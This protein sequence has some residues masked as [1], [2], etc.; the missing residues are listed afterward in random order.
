VPEGRLEVEGVVLSVK[1]REGYM[2]GVVLKMVVDG[3]GFRVW[4][5]VPADIEDDIERGSRVRFTATLTRADDDP[6]FGFFKRPAKAVLVQADPEPA[7]AAAGGRRGSVELPVVD[8]RAGALVNP[9]VRYLADELAALRAV[10]AEDV[11]WFDAERLE[12]RLH[13]LL[14]DVAREIRSN[15]PTLGAA[16]RRCAKP[17]SVFLPVEMR[18]RHH[19]SR[20][21]RL[22]A[23]EADQ[24]ALR[25][26]RV[27]LSEGLAALDAWRSW[28]REQLAR[29]LEA[30]R[31]YQQAVAHARGR[32]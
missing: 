12:R 5:T 1:E 30:H 3:G 9:Y 10:S 2:G 21:A 15:G 13:D 17:L 24:A 19:A 14:R 4:G 8:A 7:D 26:M 29:R 25:A 20:S 18:S 32:G 31:R 16:R 11:A 27:E 23:L 22:A 6:S 28:E